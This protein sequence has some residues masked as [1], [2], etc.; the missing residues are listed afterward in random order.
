[1]DFLTSLFARNGFLPHGAC[2]SWTPGLLWSMVGA[3]AVIAAAYFSIPVAIVSFVRQRG[4]APTNWLAWLFSAFIFA[5]GTTHVM[6]I[7]TVWEPDYAAQAGTKLITAGVSLATAVALWSL[8]PRALR[9]PSVAQLQGVIGSLEA[10]VRRRHT[11]EE[12]LADT[13]QSLAVTLG[14]IGAA[15][16]AMDRAGRVQRMNAVAEAL[17]G[18]REDEARG[19]PFWEVFERE[20]RPPEYLA[21]NPVDVLLRQGDTIAVAHH[22]T[23]VHRN[24]TRTKVE[25]K[26]GPTHA[27]DG[28][29]RGAVLV[30]RDLTAEIRA[31]AESSRLSALVESSDDA[32]IGKTLDG[33]ITS[34]NA[35]AQTMFGYTPEEAIGRPVQMLIPDDRAAEEMEILAR[36]ARGER[37]PPF[38]T[39][40]RAKDG[41]QVE[42]SITISPILDALG[43]IVGASKIARDVTQQRRS[44]AA[45]RDSEARLRFTLESAQ[46]G[47]WDYDLATGI[48][49]RSERHD[50]CFGYRRHPGPWTQD[51]FLAHVHPGDREEV[52]RGFRAALGGLGDWRAD[53]RVIWPD[54]TVHWISVFGST[55]REPG[56]AP[57]ML[58][59]VIDITEQKLAE[60]ARL[61]ALRLETENRQIQDANRLKSQFLANMSHELR[62]AAERDHRLRRADARRRGAGGLAEAT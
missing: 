49:H 11:A 1:M 60:S 41:R 21:Q 14:T 52:A 33:R 19:R 54:G 53:C 4:P 62:T 48:A 36:L 24:G 59:I 22:L 30:F 42:V 15:F 10:E 23:V 32:I 29:V 37:V 20:G 38:T 26:I 56:A 28:T 7:W 44:E 13:Q 17:T 31:A 18:W 51:T 57:H 50:R 2:F 45:L 25:L 35:A 55:L 47:D 3:D 46:I 58:G 43:R 9:I 12:L 39:V 27:H 6:D 34:W 40:R 16:I 5:C 61:T 8:I